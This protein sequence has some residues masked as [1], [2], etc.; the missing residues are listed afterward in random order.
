MSSSLTDAP[1][2][3]EVISVD[4]WIG[5][6]SVASQDSDGYFARHSPR[7]GLL[8]TKVADGGQ[9]EVDRAVTAAR[10][11]LSAWR[12][13]T[14]QERATVLTAVADAIVERADEFISLE[15]LETGRSA[16][17]VSNGVLNSAR[18]FRYYAAALTSHRGDAFDL[19]EG[20]HAY[21]RREPF[22]V[23]AI[24]TPWNAP[25][26]QA[27]RALGPALA[28]GNTAVVKP[29]EFTSASTVLLGAVAKAAG[30]PDGVLNVVTGTGLEAGAALIG[31]PGVDKI[32]FTGSFVTGT[33]IASIAAKRMVSCTMELGGKSAN[34]VFADADIDA[35]VEGSVHAFTYNAGQVC[36]AGSRL[37]VASE[38]HDEFVDKLV[39]RAKTRVLGTDIGPIITPGQFGK[40]QEYVTIAESEGAACRLGGSGGVSADLE[41]GQYVQPTVFTN[42]DNTMRIA[43]EE[44]F[45]PVVAVI[46]FSDEDE[47]VTIAND[48]DFGLYAALWTNDLGRAHRVAARLEAGQVVIN[49]Y[50]TD[51]VET[52]F[53][54]YKFS[55]IGR[56]KGLEALDNYSQTKS[57]IIKI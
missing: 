48:S 35:A 53:G 26:N 19:G 37:L 12:R 16:P 4:H 39:E 33:T 7:T 31:H 17:D 29:S 25:L 24:V 18:Y 5:G 11:A 22:G 43:R 36:I 40:V 30:V 44:V 20:Q 14:L 45:G 21:T 52:P 38:L 28:A 3:V 34:I 32:A 55:G 47:A 51:F 42:V 57:V 13:T 1:S 49:Q 10:D 2:D 27:A 46:P 54:G 8:I 6:S 41:G 56:E 50:L 23:V 15:A 9:W